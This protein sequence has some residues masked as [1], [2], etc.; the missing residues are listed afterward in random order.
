MWKIAT[1]LGNAIPAMLKH[2]LKNLEKLSIVNQFGVQEVFRIVFQL[3]AT[4]A[5]RGGKI[6]LQSLK[7]LTLHRLSELEVLCEGPTHILSLQNLTCFIL[8]KC[9]RLRHIFSSALAQ[10]LMQLEKLIIEHCVELEQII[11]DEGDAVDNQI[12][13]SSID[14]RLQH[15]YFPKL[16][17]LKVERCRKLKRLFHVDIA[18]G[19]LQELR[20][21]QISYNKQLKEVFEQKD[22]AA[23]WDNNEIVLGKLGLLVLIGSPSLTNFCPV[24]YHFIFPSMTGLTIFGCPMIS[25]RFSAHQTDTVHAEAKVHF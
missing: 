8:R 6:Y 7:E 20:E 21:L 2:G 19:G 24:G 16:Q 17:V 13:S 14:D 4:V 11:V 22:E 23:I 25:T 3:D 9:S 5:Q 15:V 1:I 10:N 18:R 12:I